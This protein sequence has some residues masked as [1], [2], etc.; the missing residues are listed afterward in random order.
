MEG[1]ISA[2]AV[3]GQGSVTGGAGALAALTDY[4]VMALRKLAGVKPRVH[5]NVHV[6]HQAHAH[7][8]IPPTHVHTLQ[9]LSRRR[10]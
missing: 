10:V 6:D 9:V 2:P 3:P 5:M 4:M 8:R 1:L 7:M